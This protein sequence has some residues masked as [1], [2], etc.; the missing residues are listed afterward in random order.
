MFLRREAIEAAG[1]FDEGYFFYFEDADFCRRVREAGFAVRYHPEIQLTH[2]GGGSQKGFDPV[3]VKSYR[4]GQLRYYARFGSRISF[5]G[6]KIYLSVV[7][8]F[9]LVFQRAQRTF[10][11]HMLRFVASFPYRKPARP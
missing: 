9:R 11:A 6:L 2:Y 1:G 4:A 3:V 7:I 8:S 5:Y 10:N